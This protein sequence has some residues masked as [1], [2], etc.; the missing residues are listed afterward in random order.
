M[1]KSA[2]PN[3]ECLWFKRTITD[4][5]E[6][7]TNDKSD[8]FIDI[9]GIRKSKRKGERI[10]PSEID[11]VAQSLL[12]NLKEKKISK[13]LD[14]SNVFPYEIKF[15]SNKPEQESNMTHV[16]FL[17]KLCQD[18]FLVV[19]RRISDGIK[20]REAN[21]PPK[22]SLFE[23]ITEHVKYAHRKLADFHGRDDLM[24]KLHHY[25]TNT[26]TSPFVVHGNAGTGKTSLVAM[27][28]KHARSWVKQDA[29]VVLRFLGTTPNSENIRLMLRSVCL[30]LCRALGLTMS[31]PK[32]I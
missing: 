13:V 24:K 27:A 28:A 5:K 4:L 2:D 9:K 23:E 21:E 7:I 26:C 6:N 32:V 12:K 19:K 29:V 15:S 10:N 16:Q 30:Q 25:L 18:F 17:S 8:K 11:K 22:D 14:K 1:L 3:T 20:K 31:V